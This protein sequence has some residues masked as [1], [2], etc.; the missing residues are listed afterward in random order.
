[1]KIKGK[2]NEVEVFHNRY[3]TIY[4]I[5]YGGIQGT[6]F[7]FIILNPKNKNALLKECLYPGGLVLFHFL[8]SKLISSSFIKKFSICTEYTDEILFISYLFEI[9]F[10]VIFLGMKTLFLK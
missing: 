10:I 7:E 1:M 4:K 5:V 8:V 9:Y 2:I 6:I 3:L